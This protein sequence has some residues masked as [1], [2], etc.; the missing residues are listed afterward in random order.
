MKKFESEYQEHKSLR[1][2]FEENEEWSSL[3]K[4][5]TKED[6]QILEKDSNFEAKSSETPNAKKY[7]EKNSCSLFDRQSRCGR[8][9]VLGFSVSQTQSHFSLR[10]F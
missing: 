1:N 10:F 9:R 8:F 7:L 6:R 3:L 4:E 5:E 2:I